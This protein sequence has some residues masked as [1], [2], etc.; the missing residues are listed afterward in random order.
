M[1]EADIIQ[2][3]EQACPE[4]A[5]CFQ[6][7]YQQE[8]L[9]I[10]IDRLSDQSLDYDVLTE[11]CRAAVS[12]L[13]PPQTQALMLLSRMT[14]E[15]DPDWQ[16]VVAPHSRANAPDSTDSPSAEETAMATGQEISHQSAE[17]Q[18]ETQTK[19]QAVNETTSLIA[20][21][22]DLDE[23]PS[24]T[25]NLSRYCFVRNKAL[26][27]A[28][29]LPPEP[30]V[31]ELLR[32]FH[33]L[34]ETAQQTLLPYLDQIL[35]T[36][37][38]NNVPSSSDAVTDF[39][40]QLIALSDNELRKASIW[41]SRYCHDPTAAM[42]Q[43]GEPS[44]STPKPD[45]SPATND[46][47]QQHISSV[48][49]RRAPTARAPQSAPS[50]PHLS[51][52]H[53]SI[54]HASPSRIS[55]NSL[56]RR[57]PAPQKT[58][59]IL[60]IPVIWTLL[61]FMIVSYSVQAN[62]GPDAI[63]QRCKIA[64]DAPAY[65][66]LAVQLVGTETFDLYSHQTQ[67]SEESVIAA[68]EQDCT[69]KAML[70]AGATVKGILG[71][72]QHKVDPLNAT[73][74]AILP[75]LFVFD[76][77][78]PSL[79]GGTAPVRTACAFGTL[80]SKISQRQKPVELTNHVIPNGW[81]QEPL[82]IKPLNV[83]L[84]DARSLHGLLSMLGT[85]T[86]FAAMGLFLVISLGLGIEL[87]SFSSLYL[88]AFVFGIVDAIL[89]S[90]PMVGQF[91]IIRFTAVPVLGLMM[92]ST[93]VKGMKIDLSVGYKVLALGGGILIGVRFLLNWLLLSTL[94]SMM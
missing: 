82:K 73:R 2:A 85:N 40:V 89:A 79:S 88:A 34:N 61:T 19:A 54:P 62:N 11:N 39:C 44:S 26:V 33:A 60:L 69:F 4:L 5:V 86:L 64:K 3:L 53:S 52:P 92:T 83:K 24:A 87:E 91:G 50:E 77:T 30:R 84:A 48:P 55:E 76:M 58:W 13:I 75:G 90:I 29:V 41:L 43:A 35:K 49:V 22:A 42:A 65:C 12:D 20:T 70:N 66:K 47:L 46:P 80:Q 45:P 21:E 1:N 7:I 23:S 51:H 25:V 81:P 8:I 72:E 63:A 14:G 9:Y 74:H 68:A 93:V 59:Q 57:K 18:A 31:A 15:T 38:F 67:P 28:E 10:C 17:I 56:S 16:I 71:R 37:S 78:L 36:Q 32:A 6:I 94:I 27:T